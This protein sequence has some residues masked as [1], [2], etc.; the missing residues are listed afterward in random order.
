MSKVKNL[1][2]LLLIVYVGVA[3]FNTWKPLPPGVSVSQGPFEVSAS[4]VKFLGDIT[5]RQE[6]G[7]RFFDHVIF[8]EMLAMIDQADSFVLLDMFLLN[9]WS[10]GEDLRPI[11]SE[12]VQALVSAASRG[13]KVV[14]ITDPIN[15]F[16]GGLE[17]ELWQRLQQAGGVVVV[18]DLAILRDS[19]PLYSPSWRLLVQWWGN[20][21]QGGLLPNLFDQEEGRVTLRSYLS[22]LN[23][24]ANHRKVLVIDTLSDQGRSLSTVITSANLHSASA[25]HSNIGFRIDD[26]AFGWAVLESELEIASWSDLE[27]KPPFSFSDLD[28]GAEGGSVL[29]LTLVTEEKIKLTILDQIS[30]TKEGDRVS[31]KMFYLSERDVIESLIEAAERGVEVRILLDPNKDAFGVEKDGV[32]NRSV[33]TEIKNRTNGRVNVRWCRTTGEQC[34][35]KMLIVE[36]GDRVTVLAGSANFTRRNINGYNL[37]SNVLIHGDAD[38]AV[39]SETLDFFDHYWYNRGS[40][41]L[42]LPFDQYLDDSI[43]TFWRYWL[44]ERTGLSTF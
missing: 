36:S 22:L 19:N 32:P 24:K 14:L 27:I 13:V 23:F 7:E 15:G 11:S 29:E 18:T 42:S 21:D 16:Y 25:A 28:L 33:A 41:T 9:Q 31:L 26:S 43:L 20:N 44:M 1:F 10:G 37:E 12:T 17:P 8:D 4:R 5:Y 2:L 6:G 39:L 30:N 40:A 38:T 3:V 35:S 34:H